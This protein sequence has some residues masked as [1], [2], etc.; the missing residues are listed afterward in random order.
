MNKTLHA[1]PEDTKALDLN[2]QPIVSS[3]VEA[4][5]K[6]LTRNTQLEDDLSV[7]TKKIA[8][9]QESLEQA[10][11]EANTDYL[12]GLPNRK[13]FD[14]HVATLIDDAHHTNTPLCLI[15]ADIDFFKRFN[16]TWGHKVGDQVLKLVASTLQDNT[17]GQDV[18][19]RY[20]GEEF[21]IA[22]PNTTLSNAKSLADGIRNAVQRRKLM[23]KSTNE[24]LGVITMS[25]GV[26]TLNDSKSVSELF[27]RADKALYDA[28]NSGRNCVVTE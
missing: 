8:A 24:V 20:G 16:D 2:I 19:A 27:S 6:T 15:V 21:V 4:T 7:A 13:S 11:R 9:L 10:S 1:F 12:T 25:F 28:K 17:K 5:Q 23:N 22:L 14:R 18:L 26:A 3:L